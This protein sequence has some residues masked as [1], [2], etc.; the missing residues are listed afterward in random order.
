VLRERRIEKRYQYYMRELLSGSE[1]NINSVPFLFIFNSIWNIIKIKPIVSDSVTYYSL[2]EQDFETI[3]NSSTEAELNASFF[4]ID[5]YEISVKYFLS[6]LAFRGFSGNQIDSIVVLQKLNQR[7]KQ[8]VEYQIITQEGY[9]R[10]LQLKPEVRS[11]LSLWQQNYLA[12]FYFNSMFDSITVTD[13]EVYEFF[14]SKM[15]VSSNTKMVNLRLVTLTNLEDVSDIFEQMKEGNDFGDI[16]KRYGQTDSLANNEGETGL[17]PVLLLGD[18]GKI[19]ANLELNEIYG[20]IQ[21]NNS[22]SI[23]QLIA[24]K[25]E[26]DSVKL[27]FESIKDKLRNSLRVQKLN[28]HLKTATATLAEKYNVKI[29]TE[30][31]DQIKVTEIPMFLHRFMGFGGRIAG[32]PILTPFSEWIDQ[33]TIKKMLP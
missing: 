19:A 15:I 26:D 22:Y 23:I 17:K 20:P 13:N 30:V 9:K 4:Q 33:S 32:V 28:E 2:T 6:D 25:D 21:R 3:I 12:Q 27:S 18:L 7:A 16:I 14:D 11:E 29:N 1:I 5:H 31:L 24:K 10:K 8:F